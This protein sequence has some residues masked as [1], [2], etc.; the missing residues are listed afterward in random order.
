MQCNAMQC[1]AMQCNAMQFNAADRSCAHVLA[2]DYSVAALLH[3]EQ[4]NV[5][6]W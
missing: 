2:L 4:A 6:L 5:V 1:N 3:V